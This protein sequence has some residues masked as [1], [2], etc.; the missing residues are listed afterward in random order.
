MSVDQSLV[1]PTK[2]GKQTGLS[3]PFL[4]NEFL[5][6]L[7]TSKSV[8]ESTGWLPIH[9]NLDD[10]AGGGFMPLYLKTHSMGEYVF[11]YVWA[12]AYHHHGFDYYPK[13]VSAIPFTPSSGPRTRNEKG[14]DPAQSMSFLDKVYEKSDIYKASSWHLLFPDDSALEAFADL[15]LLHRL[16]VQYQWFNYGFQT[17]DDFLASLNSRKRKMIRRERSEIAAQKIETETLFGRDIS[18]EIWDFFYNLYQRTY[19][20]RNGSP[21]YLNSRFFTKIGKSM[22]DQIAMAVAR[23]RGDPIACAL[24]FFDD[25]TLYGRYWGSIREF[26]YLHFEL[27][28]YVG[29]ELSIAMGLQR[30]DAG[31]QGEH[32]IIRGFEPRKTH[33]LH[34]IKQPNFRNAIGQFIREEALAIDHHIKE[35]NKLLPFKHS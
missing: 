6:A 25:S 14:I 33:S 21:G 22:P 12:N 32:K 35:A 1:A 20:K 19:A 8:C 24:Y 26:N 9:I 13:L 29:I 27:C 18:Q 17:F 15:N 5:N 3:Y 11:D 2:Y 16:G 31:A 23:I 30:F 10:S 28:Y 7:E 4:R 34:W